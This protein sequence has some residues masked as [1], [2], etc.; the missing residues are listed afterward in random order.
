MWKNTLFSVGLALL[1]ALLVFA[2][3]ASAQSPCA[4]PFEA[5]LTDASGEPLDG[6]V[7]LE[8]VL[9]D[10]PAD[11]AIAYDCRFLN[12]L[13]VEGGWIATT[14]DTCA[15]APDDDPCAGSMPLDE[16]LRA[17]GEETA[18][19]WI[20]VSVDG[21][22]ELTPRFALG[23]VPF[24]RFANESAVAREADFA[25]SAA[26]AEVAGVCERLGDYG[27]EDFIR[28]G[29]PIDADTLGGFTAEEL[30]AEGGTGVASS[31]AR[32]G[33]VRDWRLPNT[34][35]DF[36]EQTFTLS[37]EDD[38]ELQDLQVILQLVHPATS[39]L[40]IT[41]TSP[42]GT[43]I[44]LH[45]AGGGTGINCTYD[46]TCPCAGTV[47]T[48]GFVGESIR[49][50]WS[51]RIRDTT[52]GGAAR[53][54]RFELAYVA[55]D[56][57]VR[58]I[59]AGELSYDGTYLASRLFGGTGADG[60]LR[61]ETGVRRLDP[62]RVYNF[63]SVYV[64]PGATLTSSRAG[65]P[66]VLRVRG[67]VEILGTVLM[68][69]LGGAGGEGAPGAV[70]DGDS[71][72]GG[73]NGGRGGGSFHAE[74]GGNLYFGTSST[75]SSRGANGASASGDNDCPSDIFPGESGRDGQGDPMFGVGGLGG[76]PRS[77]GEAG[78]GPAT[79]LTAPQNLAQL[80]LREQQGGTPFIALG[81]GGGG[82]GGSAVGRLS[83]TS[84]RTWLAGGGAGGSGGMFIFVL[85][86]TQYGTP[87]TLNLGGGL[88]GAGGTNT[89]SCVRNGVSGE[90]GESGAWIVLD[91]R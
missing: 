77:G 43:T 38:G 13:T 40:N 70:S 17:I 12:D 37:V 47:C 60:M 20:G 45:S 86:G 68:D 29:D 67:D 69:G 80:M 21:E 83:S 62:N 28:S 19:A 88:G 8:L 65:A 42:E 31:T 26:Y 32:R 34:L 22:A 24:A 78:T 91:R 71:I 6:T 59:G 44:T 2:D 87:A 74:I 76:L 85:N 5:Y 52:V 36:T 57:S 61:V 56:P 30:M 55:S 39:E 1:A 7:D 72:P 63:E 66:L 89:A 50:L 9:Y 23:A 33:S 4:M 18:S 49:G 51:L 3:S 15:V 25:E 46:E 48:E 75:L 82:G 35:P 27:P 73:G 81:A 90:A 14:L 53:L 54:D 79:M 10:A 41:L 58:D 84:T 64:G 11:R 16:S